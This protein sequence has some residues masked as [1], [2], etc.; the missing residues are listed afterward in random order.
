[1]KKTLLITHINTE[2]WRKL[3]YEIS[4]ITQTNRIRY[5]AIKWIALESSRRD[6]T[7]LRATMESPPTSPGATLGR[8]SASGSRLRLSSRRSRRGGIGG[9]ERRPRPWRR[10]IWGGA[11]PWESFDFGRGINRRLSTQDRSHLELGLGFERECGRERVGRERERLERSDAS[12]LRRRPGRDGRMRINRSRS[13]GYQVST[14]CFVRASAGNGYDHT[15]E[16]GRVL[17]R[18]SR[19]H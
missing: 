13:I 19:S 4:K 2:T 7:W 5:D 15:D 3:N 10:T 11:A 1:M 6:H 17:C 14:V 9:G 8:S 12:G 16:I 18:R